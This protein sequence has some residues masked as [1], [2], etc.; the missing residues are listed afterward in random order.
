MVV[1]QAVL[2][3]RVLPQYNV[4]FFRNAVSRLVII[5]FAA[6]ATLLCE[7]ATLQSE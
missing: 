1:T 3:T 4:L 7:P 2:R 5:P 6:R